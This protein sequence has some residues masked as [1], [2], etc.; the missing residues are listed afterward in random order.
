MWFHY[1]YFVVLPNGIAVPSGDD[2]GKTPDTHK[3]GSSMGIK[4]GKEG[5]VVEVVKGDT[6][7][8]NGFD[9]TVFI[10]QNEPGAMV[11]WVPSRETIDRAIRALTAVPTPPATIH[12][13]VND[14]RMVAIWNRLY[15]RP[16]TET[17]HEF[18]IE[19]PLKGTFGE[20]WY[21][22]NSRN[23][24]LNGMSW[25]SG[26]AGYARINKSTSLPTTNRDRSTVRQP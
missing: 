5:I 13:V 7:N 6:A 9:V 14:N 1:G 11:P 25:S 12:A 21:K 26:F 16:A 2:F 10:V 18:L 24:K 4:N 17:F 15:R 23:R 22:V 3:I 8:R 19:V 20:R